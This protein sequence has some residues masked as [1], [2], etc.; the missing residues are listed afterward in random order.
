MSSRRNTM[1]EA[2]KKLK[3]ANTIFKMQWRALLGALLMLIIYVL[4]WHFYVFGL[5]LLTT[6][7]FS[8]EWVIGW[9]Q[10][11]KT[12]S[13]STCAHLIKEYIPSYNFILTLL[14]FNRTAGILIFIIFAAKKSVVLEIYDLIRG[15]KP[16]DVIKHLSFP[17]SEFSGARSSIRDTMS[18][19]I[20]NPYR[21][22]FYTTNNNYIYKND[23][24][25]ISSRT[26]SLTL[27]PIEK[28]KYESRKSEII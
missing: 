26:E 12:G 11:L 10:C 24:D 25:S 6:S 22:S 8:N 1:I 5:R 3:H 21:F 7:D 16:R 15:R 13:Q 27:A 18:S 14:F 23:D 20:N 19:N 9:I 28:A 17:G 4:N 2:Q